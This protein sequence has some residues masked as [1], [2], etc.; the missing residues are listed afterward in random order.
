MTKF[1][2]KFYRTQRGFVRSD[3]RDLY[4]AECSIQESSLA[5]DYAIWLGCDEG[6]HVDGTC[7]ARMHLN[8][9]QAAA[10]IPV[11]ERFVKSGHLPN[12]R[13]SNTGLQSD[14]AMSCAVCGST[15][16]NVHFTEPH[17]FTGTPRR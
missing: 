14:G 13:R 8:R 16:P 7:C 17:R 11:L 1:K 3:F 15:D 5:T 9:E 4:G 6:S 12:V 10:L 2:L